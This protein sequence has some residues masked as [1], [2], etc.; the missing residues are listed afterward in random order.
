MNLATIFTL[1]HEVSLWRMQRYLMPGKER[2]Q[3]NVAIENL[4]A[5]RVFVPYSWPAPFLR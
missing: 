1:G 5:I 3:L 2:Q 4:L